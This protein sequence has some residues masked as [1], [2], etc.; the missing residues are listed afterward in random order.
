MMD[1]IVRPPASANHAIMHT[2]HH[3]HPPSRHPG[4]SCHSTLPHPSTVR[5]EL[6]GSSSKSASGA[7][8][9]PGVPRTILCGGSALPLHAGPID[10]APGESVPQQ[11]TPG[12]RL[13]GGSLRR[14]RHLAHHDCAVRRAEETVPPLT[15]TRPSASPSPCIIHARNT[16]LASVR[17]HDSHDHGRQGSSHACVAATPRS[18]TLSVQRELRP[19]CNRTVRT[20]CP[21]PAAG[22]A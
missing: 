5:R 21:T 17:P 7:S 1:P 3:T 14:V 11:Y 16:L 19:W 12:R 22:R 20:R 8:A 13:G 9:L 10:C 15:E 6:L 2:P 18:R 4:H